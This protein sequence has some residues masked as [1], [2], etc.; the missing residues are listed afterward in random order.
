MTKTKNKNRVRASARKPK[1][2]R[3]QNTAKMNAAMRDFVPAHYI[4]II[5]FS[6]TKDQDIYDPINWLDSDEGRCYHS[7]PSGDLE[8][9]NT[10]SGY[11]LDTRRRDFGFIGQQDDMES[12]M[13]AFAASPF[14]VASV[15]VYPDPAY[16][17]DYNDIK[18]QAGIDAMIRKEGRAKAKKGKR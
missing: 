18:Q 14:K 13:R 10:G 5:E 4:L 16:F 9:M 15:S 3:Q 2:L 11:N 8:D 6:L 12:I 7:I 1:S 17:S